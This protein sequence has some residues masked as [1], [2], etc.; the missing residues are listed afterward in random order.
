V[1]G[2]PVNNSEAPTYAS[3]RRL[4]YIPEIG[5]NERSTDRTGQAIVQCLEISGTVRS[6]N[7]P[8]SIQYGTFIQETGH[9]IAAPFWQFM[10]S[11]GP[12][13]ENGQLVQGRVFD[14]VSAMGFPIAEPFWV[15]TKLNGQSKQVLVQLFQRRVLTYTPG[16]PAGFL[17]EMGNVGQHYYLWRYNNQDVPWLQS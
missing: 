2:D 5:Q 6:C 10:A 11:S 17:V 4:V 15:T 7:A 13:L 12:V 16:N 3:F 9:N 14:W 1:A 8:E